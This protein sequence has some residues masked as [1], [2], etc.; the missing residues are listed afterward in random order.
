MVGH[1]SQLHR[2]KLTFLFPLFKVPKT[3]FSATRA[4]SD[5]ALSRGVLQVYR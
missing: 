3:T 5:M 4:D 1:T 2:G